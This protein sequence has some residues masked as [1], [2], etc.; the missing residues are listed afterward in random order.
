MFGFWFNLCEVVV[1]LKGVGLNVVGLIGMGWG[2]FYLVLGD[3]VVFVVL[4][5]DNE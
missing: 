3:L 4:L 2:M 5:S 1:F